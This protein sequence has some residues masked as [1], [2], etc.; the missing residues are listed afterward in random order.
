M[1][2]LDYF[3]I[4]VVL[5]SLILG[6]VRGFIKSTISLLSAIVGLLAAA[7]LYPPVGR[8]LDSLFSSQV[9]A[10]FAAFGLIFLSVMF[11][12]ALLAWAIRGFL[13]KARI[14]W[15]D[16]LL[17]AG[18][19]LIRGWLICSVVYLALT[20]FPLKI[21]AVEKAQLSPLLIQGTRIVSYAGSGELRRQF[22]KGY[23]TV[24]ESWHKSR[25]QK[26]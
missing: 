4:I 24:T 15:T 1:T 21:E 18:F 25:V 7:Y 19:G 8:A 12:G 20:A 26:P 23:E 6:A 5:V 14:T 16:H 2:A 17:G 13:R 3:V 22:E 10:D 9:V 11:A